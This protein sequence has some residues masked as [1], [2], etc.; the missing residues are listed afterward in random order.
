MGALGDRFGRKL[1]LNAG[2]AIFGLAS[3][4]A[5]F[6]GSAE[7]LIAAR[8]AMG[9]GGALIMPST[10]SIITNIFTGEERGRAI[11]AW[12][13]VAGLGIIIGPVL[14]GWLLEHFWWGSV[15]LL[16]LPVVTVAIAAGAVLVPESKDPRATPLDPLGAVLSITGLAALVYGLIEAPANGWTDAVVLGAFG[17][18]AVLLAASWHGSCVPDTRCCR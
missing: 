9:I 17:L 7:V 11:A 10:L 18:A 16:N 2:L 15:F 12:A 5:A 3:L 1:T 6:S 14:G 4:A 13:A 8:G